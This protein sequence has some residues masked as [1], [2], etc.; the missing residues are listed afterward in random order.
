ML[1]S[2]RVELSRESN[3]TQSHSQGERVT[4]CRPRLKTVLQVLSAGII[5]V[6]TARLAI[7]G[8]LL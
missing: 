3:K 8:G 2:E 4:L 7:E 6:C 1:C 5:T